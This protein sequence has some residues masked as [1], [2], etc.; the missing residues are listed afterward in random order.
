MIFFSLLCLGQVF[1]LD[2][3]YCAFCDPAN[4]EHSIFYEDDLVL[5]YCTYKPMT[6][7][8]FLVIPKRHVE[9]FEMLTDEEILQIGHAIKKLHLAVSE[10]FGANSYFLLQKNGEDAGQTVPHVH[11]HYVGRHDGDSST[12]SVLKL[13]L[14]MLIRPLLS[15]LSPEQIQEGAR[16]IRQAMS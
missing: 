1:A 4:A 14:K 2:R 7:E 3:S 12:F 10:V 9:R 5:G 15:P 6:P 11:F 16:A 13:Y 8:H